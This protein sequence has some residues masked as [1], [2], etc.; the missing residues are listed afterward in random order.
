MKDVAVGSLLHLV[1]IK[2]F[3]SR[4]LGAAKNAPTEQVTLEL[5]TRRH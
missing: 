1:A 2:G 4:R 5:P 3:R